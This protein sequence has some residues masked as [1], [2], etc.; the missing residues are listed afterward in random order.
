MR[1]T[2]IKV[3]WKKDFVEK[4][5]PFMPIT[6]WMGDNLLKNASEGRMFAM[7]VNP[8]IPEALCTDRLLDVEAQP[9]SYSDAL[10]LI[11]DLRKKLRETKTE[12]KEL[13]SRRRQ[14]KSGIDC[15]IDHYLNSSLCSVLLERLPWLI[16]LLLIESVSAYSLSRFQS[17]IDRHMTLALFCPMIV[18]T[19]GNAGN[20]PGVIFTRAVTTG[21]FDSGDRMQRFIQREMVVALIVS[22]T[23]A[24]VALARTAV[25]HGQA[26]LLSCVAVAAALFVVVQFA[27]FIGILFSFLLHRCGV[28]PAAGAAPLLTTL[29]DVFGV[30]LLCFISAS[31]FWMA[32]RHMGDSE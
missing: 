19:A 10:D 21:E 31:I 14:S 6:G 1:K 27:I 7:H 5:T 13:G 15:S 29:S 11:A 3:G 25:E 20:Q 2:L 24:L 26:D 30:L 4:N 18:G 28:D 32:G 16:G 22:G 8:E 23:L 17:L 12:L 9:G